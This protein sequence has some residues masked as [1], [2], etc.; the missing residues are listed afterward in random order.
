MLEAAEPLFLPGFFPDVAPI[1]ALRTRIRINQGALGDARNW[2]EEHDRQI[3]DEATYLAEYD[4]LT[5]ARLRVAEHRPGDD[6]ARLDDVLGLLDRILTAAES[7]GRAGSLVEA[8]LVR[9]LALQAAGDVDRAVDD[10]ARALDLG[11]PVGYQRLFLDEGQPV[12]ELLR[13]V[14]Q[15]GGD[16]AGRQADRLLRAAEQLQ[17]PGD[18]SSP[19]HP[20]FDGSRTS[21][22]D[23]QLSDRELEVLHLLASE[24][25]GP[26]M[27][28]RLF[29]S[30]NTLRTHTRHIFTKLGVNTRRAAV[31]RAAELGLL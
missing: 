11:A 28:S 2:A 8:R 22:Y 6:P 4:Q 16:T 29:V 13:L 18:G 20:S 7:A 26:Q 12:H 23:E 19:P 21:G 27:A 30:V 24:L 3:G 14:S 15:R 10:L 1:P 31:R 17:S 9:S 5:L 25:T